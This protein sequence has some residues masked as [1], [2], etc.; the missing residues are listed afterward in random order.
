M[1]ASDGRHGV[2]NGAHAP[3]FDLIAT[4]GERFSLESFSP[5]QLLV[6]VFLAN[7]CPF[8]TAWEDRLIVLAVEH[9]YA[10]VEARAREYV[11]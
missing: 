9:G 4:D 3:A 2:R 8:V 11:S 10:G 1:T 7:H 5:D 6:L